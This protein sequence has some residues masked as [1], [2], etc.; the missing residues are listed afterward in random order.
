MSAAHPLQ[1]EGAPS[2]QTPTDD[3]FIGGRPRLPPNG[4]IPSCGLCKAEQTFF[5]QVAFPEDHEW[6]GLSLATFACTSC[7]DENHLIPPMLK[8]RRRK[9]IDIP[10]GFLESYQVNFRFRV[11]ETAKSVPQGYDERVAFHRWLLQPAQAAGA[12][13]KL[14][15][16]PDWL[17]DDEAPAT[18][19]GRTPMV[20]LMQIERGFEFPLVPGAPPQMELALDG[21]PEPAERPYYQLFIG[22]AI[23]LFGTQDR[24]QPLVYAIT[25][26]L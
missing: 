26:V 23:Y 20:F 15:G 22:N 17:Q 16:T 10:E 11:F 8:G 7:A 2:P 3:R 1:L 4:P 12:G 14:G 21:T 25:Q 18:Y 5:F 24:S 6:A 19:A 9:A 13:T